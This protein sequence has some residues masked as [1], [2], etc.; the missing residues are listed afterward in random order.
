M[1][2]GNVADVGDTRR[3]SPGSDLIAQVL[4]DD[5]PGT[6]VLQAWGGLNTIARALMTIEEQQTD[7]PQWEAIRARVMARTVLTSWGEQDDTFVSYI[8]PHWPDMELRQVATMVWGYAARMVTPADVHHYFSSEWMRKN[9]SRVGPVGAAYRV[10][11]D[12]LQMAAGFDP[13]DYFG[14]QGLSR[15]ELCARGYKVFVPVQEPGAWISEGDTSNFALHIDNGLRNWEHPGNGGWGGR[16][17]RDP[18]DPHRWNS[19]GFGGLGF[20][21]P[22]MDWGD[23][24]RWV[25]AFQCDFAARLQWSV[26]D[27]Y[28]AA[29]HPPRLEVLSGLDVTAR[30]GEA[31]TVAWSVRDPD[32]DAVSVTFWQYREAGSCPSEALIERTG[33]DTVTVTVPSAAAAGETIHVILEATDNGEPPLTAY[34]RIIV[35]VE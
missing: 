13:E 3:P 24:A 5:E 1:R 6:V 14:L 4:L 11:G 2:V 22:P 17:V 33:A 27:E 30:P 31:I 34:A 18:K 35:T 20:G 21:K 9:V 15:E 10:W 26:S 7:S 25:S 16:Q 29:N 19:V 32:G 12:G 23:V 8:R 28:S